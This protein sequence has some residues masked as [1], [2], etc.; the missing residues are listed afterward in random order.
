[1]A[2]VRER[3][4]QTERTALAGEFGA[5]FYGE[6]VPRGQRDGS[7]D[8]FFLQIL[9]TK[10]SAEWRAASLLLPMTLV[11]QFW[12]EEIRIE[13]GILKGFLLR[14][15]LLIHSILGS[16]CTVSIGYYLRKFSEYVNVQM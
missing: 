2:S 6:K 7:L 8:R 3:S 15:A 14:V 5:N 10:I 12:V 1:V 16:M 13:H 11:F 4:I 9:I